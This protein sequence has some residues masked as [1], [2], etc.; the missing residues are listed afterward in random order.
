MSP[1]ESHRIAVTI[2]PEREED[3]M[4]IRDVH[5]LAFRGEAEARLVETLRRSPEFIPDLSLV[6]SADGRIAGHILFTP[7]TIVSEEG[8]TPALALAP[9]AVRPEFQ[10]HGIGSKLVRAGLAACR[11]LK[12]GIVVVLGHPEYYPRF[13]FVPARPLGIRP[14]YDVGDRYFMVCA[15][16]PGVLDGVEGLVTY[17]AAFNTV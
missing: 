2:R 3:V 12:H 16:E 15:T 7:I 10:R 13:G 1:T 4:A 14:P 17:P 6:A 5:L 11:R 8:A 9:M